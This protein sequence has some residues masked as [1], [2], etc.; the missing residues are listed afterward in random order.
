MQHVIISKSCEDENS[1]GSYTKS[2]INNKRD[3]VWLIDKS[4]YS[5][6]ELKM[7]IRKTKHGEEKCKDFAVVV[8]TRRVFES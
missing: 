4:K 8:L 1:I 5:I 7:A 3:D 2:K 6:F